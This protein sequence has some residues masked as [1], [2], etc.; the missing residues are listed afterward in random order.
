ML[1]KI[2]IKW[3]NTTLQLC[4]LFVIAFIAT[5]LTV[6]SPRAASLIVNGNGQ[7]TGATNV[8]LGA[9]GIFDVSLVEGSCNSLFGSCNEATDFDFTSASDVAVAVQALSNSVFIDS[10]LGNFDTDP[11]LT[12][13]CEASLCLVVVP[14]IPT[15][16]STFTGLEFVNQVAETSDDTSGISISPF[17]NTATSSIFVFADF[18]QVSVVP[19][20]AALPLYGTGLAI[21]GFLG[22]R[23][24]RVSAA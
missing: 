22:W 8:D 17:F 7:L 16:L 5:G 20:P 14:Y 15:S 13:G 6:I 1:F 4:M 10:P 9:L 12:F 11:S 2:F 19:L 23:R 18:T 21:M 24:K 3:Q